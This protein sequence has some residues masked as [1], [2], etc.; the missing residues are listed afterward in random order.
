MKEGLQKVGEARHGLG[1]QQGMG[2]GTR[3]QIQNETTPAARKKGHL[4]PRNLAADRQGLNRER[5]TNLNCWLPR[6]WYRP[7]SVDTARLDFAIP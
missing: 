2:G 7:I 6:N 1:I 5:W 4:R 3:A